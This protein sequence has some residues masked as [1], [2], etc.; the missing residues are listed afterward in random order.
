MKTNNLKNAFANAING[1]I[2]TGIKERNFKI[3]LGIM[4]LVII[5][6]I[7]LSI[8]SSQWIVILL[9]CGLVLT[10]E[11]FNTALEKLADSV[12]TQFDPLIKQAKDIAAGA[13]LISVITSMTIGLIIFIPKMK[14]LLC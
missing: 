8:S 2:S 13:V 1:I 7:V 9:C 4:V 3:E 10:L 12:T 11:L 6:G 14:L 5:G